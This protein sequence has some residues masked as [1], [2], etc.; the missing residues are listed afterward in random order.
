MMFVMKS[1]RH[2]NRVR[3]C[4]SDNSIDKEEMKKTKMKKMMKQC[5]DRNS[6]ASKPEDT[7]RT[8]HS[9]NTGKIFA[10][11]KLATLSPSSCRRNYRRRSTR[12][13]SR[14]TSSGFCIRLLMSRRNTSCCKSCW[15]RRSRSHRRRKLSLLS[16]MTTRHELRTFAHR[17]WRC[18]ACT[19]RRRSGSIPSGRNPRRRS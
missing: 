19:R 16:R 11:T 18:R 7:T 10:R 12:Q 9:R 1:R 17:W 8:M 14:S 4:S 6:S 3:R 15:Y 2:D 5:S 13:S